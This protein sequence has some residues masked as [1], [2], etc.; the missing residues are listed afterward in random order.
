MPNLKHLS[1]LLPLCLTLIVFACVWV[2]PTPYWWVCSECSGT[3]SGFGLLLGHSE[4]RFFLMLSLVTLATQTFGLAYTQQKKGQLRLQIGLFLFFIVM[5]GFVV[6]QHLLVLLF[7]WELLSILSFFLIAFKNDETE[8]VQSAVFVFALTKVADLGLLC[9]VGGFWLHFGR[10]DWAF[11][12]KESIQNLPAWLAWSLVLAGLGKSAQVVF[13]W[14]L[15]AAM[16][17]PTPVSA[18]LHAA[19]LVTTGILLWSKFYILLVT[20]SHFLFYSGLVTVL[21]ATFFALFEKEAKRV[22]ALSTVASMGLISMTLFSKDSLLA[23]E[24]LFY[25][26]FGKALAFV[27]VGILCV[28]PNS[29]G[30]LTKRITYWAFLF[31][32]AYLLGLPLS[33]ISQSKSLFMSV[34]SM[35]FQIL[36]G[37]CLACSALILGKCFALLPVPKDKNKQP[38]TSFFMEALPIFVLL[39]S[40]LALGFGWLGTNMSARFMNDAIS[41]LFMSGLSLLGYFIAQ[42]IP[43]AAF[44][45]NTLAQIKAA[46][47][48]PLLLSQTL[49]HLE[50][51]LTRSAVVLMKSVVVFGHIAKRIDTYFIDKLVHIPVWAILQFEKGGNHSLGMAAAAMLWSIA[52]FLCVLGCW[53]L[54]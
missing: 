28:R 51:T 52:V 54:L 30:I 25:H 48:T 10:L 4:K 5:F 33:G 1:C 42:K 31:T 19:A 46:I 35:N 18:L 14:W 41:F 27:C 37:L 49:V 2:L 38:A 17:A 15:P 7:F 43:P 44:F 50:N 29:F 6:A 3:W 9:F 53:W 22:L 32:I 23:Q 34:L 40:I 24:W 21:M 47:A 26:G 36:F 20:K 16:K 12:Q 13:F 39:T 45:N 8:A 11:L